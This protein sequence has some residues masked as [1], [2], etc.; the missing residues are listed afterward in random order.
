MVIVRARRRGLRLGDLDSPQALFVPFIVLL[1]L[2]LVREHTRNWKAAVARALIVGGCLAAT[3]APW[4]Y[5]NYKT[6]GTFV[7]VSTNGGENLLIGNNPVSEQR[8]QDPNNLR[9][10]PDFRWER[11]VRLWRTAEVA[12]VTFSCNLRLKDEWGALV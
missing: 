3:V 10:F 8:Y 12:P 2:A 1:V 5:R 6:F 11:E 7:L 9:P 4:T